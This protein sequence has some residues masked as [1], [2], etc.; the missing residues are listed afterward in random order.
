MVSIS[1][2]IDIDSDFV[3][4]TQDSPPENE[5]CSGL[6]EIQIRAV[7]FFSAHSASSIPTDIR[8]LDSTDSNESPE[9][10]TDPLVE[11]LDPSFD[12][13]N[14]SLL[15]LTKNLPMNSIIPSQHPI[16]PFN[17]DG[18]RGQFD[19]GAGVSCTNQQYL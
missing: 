3:E 4:P 9:D 16:A 10:D 1:S 11:N 19:T 8:I 2:T 5:S 17:P 15:R 13:D 14:P 18:I 7:N 12:R 6:A